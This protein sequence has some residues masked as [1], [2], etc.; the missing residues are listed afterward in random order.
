MHNSKVFHTIS[1]AIASEKAL[2]VAAVIEQSGDLNLQQGL[3]MLIYADGTSE[4]SLGRLELEQQVIATAINM[5]AHNKSRTESYTLKEEQE[6]SVYIESILPP[7]PCIIIGADPDAQAIVRLAAQMGFKVVLVDHREAFANQHR[8]PEAHR[9]IV[10]QP[11]EFGN[12]VDITSQSYII[13]K[14]H[15]YLRDK[16]I[17]KAALKSPARY[18]GQLGPKARTDDLLKDLAEE[19]HVFTD[20]EFSRLYAP[21][22]LDLGAETPEAIAVSIV[23]EML[24]VNNGREGGFLREQTGAIHPR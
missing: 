10:A 8:Y 11:E 21:V 5:L 23:G 24:A 7:S 9:V 12:S 22:G 18:I 19:G 4:G 20:D 3:R 17:L 15:H 16:E 2:A 13:I 1:Q 6:V 14:T